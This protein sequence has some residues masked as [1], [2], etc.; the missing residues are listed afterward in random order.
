V[1]NLIIT[2]CNIT[3]NDKTSLADRNIVVYRGDFNVQVTFSITQNNGFKYLNNTT[4]NNLIE[5]SNASYA[6]MIVKLQDSDEV[7]ILT[8]IEPTNNGKVTLTIIKEYIDELV[9]VGAYDYQ[10]RLFSY[11]KHARITIPPVVG[12]L[13]V[14]EPIMFL[15]DSATIN[16]ASVDSAILLIEDTSIPTFDDEG[17]YN[18]TDWVRGNVITDSKLNKVENALEH[19]T[20]NDYI[21]ANLKADGSIALGHN[22][23]ADAGAM[24]KSQCV[25]GKYN[26][27]D[28]SALFI[29]GSG[30]SDNARDNSLVVSN[31]KVET[32]ILSAEQLIIQEDNAPVN[33]MLTTDGLL[34]LNE[35][36]VPE[37]DRYVPNKK[38]VDDAINRLIRVIGNGIDEYVFT[39]NELADEDFTNTEI[40]NTVLFKNVR[41]DYFDASGKVE[42]L[43]YSGDHILTIITLLD[44]NGVKKLTI[45]EKVDEG[46][47][48][49]NFTVEDAAEGKVLIW[50][51]PTSLLFANRKDVEETTTGLQQGIELL[52]SDVGVIIDTYATK[53]ELPTVPTDVSAFTNDA[54]YLTEHQSLEDYALKTDIPSTDGLATKEE[55]NNALGDIETLLGG[56]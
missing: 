36:Y 41:V 2:D 3:V 38:Y 4:N 39:G 5:S 24:T 25:V 40:S 19:I 16:L 43:L 6:Q 13:I 37:D 15:D 22:L 45:E 52:T 56:I 12:Q 20:S 10:I 47:N 42:S 26:E 8:E 33:V 9:E 54:G 28:T 29:V 1:N 53:E 34:Y 44:S 51:E 11:E 17:K 35:N 27:P 23:I 21:K 18:K 48:K 46:T 50:E 55:L 31:G 30:T 7:I 14:K 49:I 32:K